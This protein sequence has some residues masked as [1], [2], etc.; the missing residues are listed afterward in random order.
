MISI[1]LEPNSPFRA[2]RVGNAQ[3]IDQNGNVSC[4]EIVENAS[5]LFPDGGLF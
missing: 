5:S 3:D 4:P 1:T 2:E